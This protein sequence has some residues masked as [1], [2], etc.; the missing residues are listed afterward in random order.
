M[1]NEGLKDFFDPPRI[2]SGILM[3]FSPKFKVFFVLEVDIVAHMFAAMSVMRPSIAVVAEVT[4]VMY[5]M[6]RG[7][8]TVYSSFCAITNP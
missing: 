3:V 7:F 4:R 6:V 2:Y 8:C 1:V 5:F